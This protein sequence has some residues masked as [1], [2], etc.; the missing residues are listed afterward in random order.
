M[1][2]QIILDQV[3]VPADIKLVNRR[4]ILEYLMSGEKCT[5]ADICNATGISKPT[6]MRALQYFCERGLLKSAG[7]GASTRVG[8]KRPEYFVFSDMRKILCI[9]LWPESITFALSNLVGDVYALEEYPHVAQDN[10]DDV[11]ASLEHLVLP[12]LERRGVLLSD[13]YGVGISMSG[14]VDYK[15]NLLHYNAKSPGWGRNIHMEDY[16]RPIFGEIPLYILENAGRACGRAL[17]L[18][19]PQL[20]ERRIL[21]LFCT[22]GLSACLIENGHVLSGKDALIGEIGHMLV[23]N[24]ASTQCECGKNGCLERSVSLACIIKMLGSD[25]PLCNGD[26]PLTLRRLFAASAAGDSSA[27]KVVTYLA[28]CFAI[29]LHNLVLVYNPDVVIF[30]GDFALADQHFDNCLKRELAEFR[31]FPEEGICEIRYDKR[32]LSWLAAR[33]SAAMLQQHYFSS[34]QFD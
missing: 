25:H 4:K 27:Q 26:R 16:L 2:K 7:L 31:Y 8:G 23:D 14:T 34:M 5:V 1:A 29:A 21:S 17:L 12:Y 32:E 10:L 19:Q 20:A 6:T 28:H 18:D 3:T 11:F 22:W 9:A 33:G 13:L 30:Q 15:M 24:T